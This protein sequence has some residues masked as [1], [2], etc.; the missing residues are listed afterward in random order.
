MK[1]RLSAQAERELQSIFEYIYSD[2]PKAAPQMVDRL[3]SAC[4]ELGSRPLLYP[5]APRHE[6]RGLRR[7]V[8]GAYGIYYVVSPELVEVVTILHSA[9]DVDR[10][11]F[12]ED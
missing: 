1:V 6:A 10:L 2:S 12:P 7:R 11:L 8:L 3:M 9:R 5:L 4:L